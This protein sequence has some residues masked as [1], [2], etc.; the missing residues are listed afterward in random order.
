VVLQKKWAFRSHGPNDNYIKIADLDLS[1]DVGVL[2]KDFNETRCYTLRK[3]LV[4]LF[5]EVAVCS[6]LVEIGLMIE[7]YH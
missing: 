6:L 3:I 2:N 5:N 4:C 1:Y 7:L